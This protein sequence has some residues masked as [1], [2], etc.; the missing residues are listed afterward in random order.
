[1][2]F[3]IRYIAIF[4]ALIILAV[5]VLA[6]QVSDQMQTANLGA[7][8]AREASLSSYRAAQSLKALTAG[9]E[10]TMNEFYSTVLDFGAYQKKANEQRAAIEHELGILSKLPDSDAKSNVEI[11]KLYQNIDVYRGSLEK[12]LAGAEGQDWDRAREALYKANVLSVQAIHRADVIAKL[13]QDHALSLDKRWQSDGSQAQF[14]LRIV[15]ILSLAAS[16]ILLLGAILRP[17]NMQ[18]A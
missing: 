16:I 8:N 13:A 1:M 5:S 9:Y 18:S 2:K 6:Y 12:A 11:S 7:Q 14:L 15:M 4:A 3:S 10:L 17:R